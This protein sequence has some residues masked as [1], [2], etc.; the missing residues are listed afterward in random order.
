MVKDKRPDNLWG[1]TVTDYTTEYFLTDDEK[2][3]IYQMVMDMD[4]GSYPDVYD[5]FEGDGY[6]PPYTC[7]LKVQYNDFEKT[8]RCYDIAFI[9][10]L[11]TYQN[12]NHI[13]YWLSLPKESR[14]FIAL[15]NT[16]RDILMNSKE[17]NDLPAVEA[18][19]H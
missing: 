2:M 18:R 3:M 8:V 1:Y 11:E 17:W 14:D 13:D 19:D 12:E 9:G 5:P 6:S 15:H 10:S 7:T 16:I 4:F